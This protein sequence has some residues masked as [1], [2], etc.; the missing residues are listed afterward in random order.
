MADASQLP[1]LARVGTALLIAGLLDVVVMI[2]CIANGVSY[3]SSFNIFAVWLGIL[4]IRGSLWA[5]S[6]V[7]FFVAFFLAGSIGLITAFPLLQPVSLTLAEL[8]HVSPLTVV[9]SL[10]LLS[11]SFWAGYELNREPVIAALKVSGRSVVPLLV[12]VVLGFGLVGA[13]ASVIIFT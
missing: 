10:L 9:P 8:R 3:A 4:L 2:Y 12:P 11:L 1:I 7:R 13:V 6:V 5:A